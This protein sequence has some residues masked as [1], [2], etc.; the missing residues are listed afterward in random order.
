VFGRVE[1]VHRTW[2]SGT[3]GDLH[4]RTFVYIAV[5]ETWAGEVRRTERSCTVRAD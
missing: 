4:F 2:I 5:L 1:R 3:E